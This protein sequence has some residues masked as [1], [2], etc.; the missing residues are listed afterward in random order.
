MYEQFGSKKGFVRFVYHR[1]LALLGVYRKY[2]P[3]AASF[4][5]RRLVFICSGN[6]CRSPLAEVYASSLGM[7]AASCGLH[8]GDDYPADPRAREFAKTQ[9][10]SLEHHKTVNVRNFEFNDSD[11]IVAME[12][13]HLYQFEEKV[14]KNYQLVLA[15]SYS[16]K[17]IPYIHD[18]FN[19]C[20]EF[21]TRCENKVMEC[22]R[23]LDA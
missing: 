20:P 5:S 19:C 12:P 4:A 17:P 2:S 15:G 8:C 21:F 18:P 11:I 7:D 10:L 9:G 14:G 3:K 13:S 16:Q 6:I 22:V 23:G 1:A